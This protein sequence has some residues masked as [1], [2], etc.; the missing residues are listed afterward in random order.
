VDGSKQALVLLRKIWQNI[1]CKLQEQHK[2]GDK[3]KSQLIEG[4]P[5]LT[6]GII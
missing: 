6:T 5:C 2:T 1:I 4:Y 3:W